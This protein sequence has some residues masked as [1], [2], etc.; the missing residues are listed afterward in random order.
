[1][2][3]DWLKGVMDTM[4]D[5]CIVK[6]NFLVYFPMIFYTFFVFLLSGCS[7]ISFIF[8]VQEMKKILI[9]KHITVLPTII[10]N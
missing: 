1:V 6:Y 3:Q 9:R 2:V 7:S 5:V 8:L 10:G 4:Y